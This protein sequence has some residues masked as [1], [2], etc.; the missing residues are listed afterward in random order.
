MIDEGVFD[1]SFLQSSIL[2]KFN[3]FWLET[4]MST[5]PGHDHTFSFIL[6]L[7]GKGRTDSAAKL[8][9]PT[10]RTGPSYGASYLENSTAG[11]NGLIHSCSILPS[12]HQA[13]CI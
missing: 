1:D 4:A 9:K 10:K 11:F 8:G 5:L 13:Q 6:A 7:D 12:V 2:L 3:G